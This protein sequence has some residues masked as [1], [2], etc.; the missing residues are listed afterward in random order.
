MTQENISVALE[1]QVAALTARLAAL[2]EQLAEMQHLA[3]YYR[4]TQ[5]VDEETM[6]V[7]SAAVA[8][9]LGYKAR[10]KAVRLAPS[11]GWTRAGRA[12]VQDHS[13][14]RPVIRPSRITL[15]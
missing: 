13:R 15:R 1:Q 4:E 10:V 9:V 11:V 14:A 7:V 5:K 8:A 2:E 3:E 6:M 12:E